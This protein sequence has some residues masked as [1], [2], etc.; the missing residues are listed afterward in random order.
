MS[1]VLN[2]KEVAAVLGIGEFR[3][4]RLVAEEKLLGDFNPESGKLEIDPA[5]VQTYMEA[6]KQPR[7]RTGAVEGAKT[8]KIKL[9][10][11]QVAALKEDPRF[12]EVEI[13]LGYSYNPEASKA[14]RI[15][16][17]QEQRAL[18]EKVRAEMGLK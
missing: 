18:A 4:R 8:Y 7:T 17:Q 6:R 2:V 9:T 12:A 15:K 16:R 14:Y 3:V 1:D 13:K 5:S 10:A 11:E